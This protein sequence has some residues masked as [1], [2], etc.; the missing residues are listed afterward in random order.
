MNKI[1]HYVASTFKFLET[2]G[3]NL[4]TTTFIG[5]SLGAHVVGVAEVTTLKIKLIL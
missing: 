3:M 5:I 1:G 4:N 2:K